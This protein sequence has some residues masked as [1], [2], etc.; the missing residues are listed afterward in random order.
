MRASDVIDGKLPTGRY[1]VVC[2]DS[3]SVLELAVNRLLALGYALH[4]PL[5][6]TG[7]Y[8]AQPMLDILPAGKRVREQ[9]GAE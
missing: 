7:G 6:H 3:L 1:V 2:D 8:Y 9:K 4:W 5:L